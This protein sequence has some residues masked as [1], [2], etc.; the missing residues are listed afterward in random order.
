MPFKDKQKGKKWAKEYQKK[1]RYEFQNKIYEYKKKIGKCKLCGWNDH[2]EVLQFHHLDKSK[3]DFKFSVGHLGC[4]AWNKI[5]KEIKKCILICP[6]C[7]SWLHYKEKDWFKE[8]A[9]KNL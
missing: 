7:H 8:I 9:K 6:N 4:F 2:V 5:E 1:R 3:K